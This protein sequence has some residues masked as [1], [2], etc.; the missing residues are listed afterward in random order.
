MIP[1]ISSIF[2]PI[3]QEPQRRQRPPNE[4]L[5]EH[6]LEPTST[7]PEME[8]EP[9]YL[10]HDEIS[11]ID[12]NVTTKGSNTTAG[13]CPTAM[14]TR[15]LMTIP[16]CTKHDKTNSTHCDK[17]NSTHSEELVPER[18]DTCLVEMNSL[19]HVRQETNSVKQSSNS[20]DEYSGYVPIG[21]NDPENCSQLESSTSSLRITSSATPSSSSTTTTTTT[22]MTKTRLQ[23]SHSSFKIDCGC[24]FV[25]NRQ[26]HKKE[27]GTVM[28]AKMIKNH[29]SILQ[30]PMKKRNQANCCSTNKNH[31]NQRFSHDNY[32]SL[33]TKRSVALFMLKI[34][35]HENDGSITNNRSHN[36]SYIRRKTLSSSS[37]SSSSFPIAIIMT[38]FI[39]VRTT[40]T[41]PMNATMDE[42]NDNDE[43]DGTAHVDPNDNETM[44]TMTMTT[45]D[46]PNYDNN[47]NNNHNDD[48]DD[49]DAGTINDDPNDNDQ[50]VEVRDNED[51]DIT[52][53]TSSYGTS[54]SQRPGAYAIYGMNYTESDESRTIIIG[55]GGSV[56]TQEQD[57]HLLQQAR[58]LERQ[59]LQSTFSAEPVVEDAEVVVAT[60]T[61]KDGGPVFE[62]EVIPEEL[63][64]SFS[65]D[66]SSSTSSQVD[67]HVGRVKAH[68][69]I[70]GGILIIILAI[71]III[72]IAVVVV[73]TDGATDEVVSPGNDGE[74][75]P[76]PTSSEAVNSTTANPTTTLTPT[77]SWMPSLMPT[78]Q[79]LSMLLD[80]FHTVPGVDVVALQN[81]TSPQHRAIH[82]LADNDGLK[83]TPSDD[84][85][86]LIERYA[87]VTLYY[88][89]N[90]DHEAVTM[91]SR[92]WLSETTHCEWGG[93]VC[94]VNSNVVT[95]LQLGKVIKWPLILLFA[96]VHK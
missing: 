22:R 18:E 43:D 73:G 72:I 63:P 28:D 54:V 4:E 46:N 34:N 56:T 76:S 83:L 31:T 69:F 41:T 93:V 92:V 51:G 16:C 32:D 78:S 61:I 7:L 15:K 8:R 24:F 82:W 52:S 55:G 19:N 26:D 64:S 6:D 13:V 23:Q 1:T 11:R 47:G 71:V 42:P 57:Q 38:A 95:V 89:T 70:M 65:H 79:E 84:P 10:L 87:L 58:I 21:N 88:A 85:S 12:Q 37:S 91:G 39:G 25:D 14:T 62:G 48:D 49:D 36:G 68:H 2:R 3:S 5:K 60:S 35:D 77:I 86:Y 66:A 44:N 30:P 45:T 17:T 27:I 40:T 74:G 9:H 80:F 67:E 53:T 90:A 94:P 20:W 50:R 59:L 75:A 33:P 81:S 29:D 96:P